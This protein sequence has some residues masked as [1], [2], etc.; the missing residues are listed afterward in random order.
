MILCLDIGNSQIYGGVFDNEKIKLKFRKISTQGSS[1]DEYGLFLKSV[2][3]E[4]GLDPNQIKQIAICS[5]VPD[6]IYSICNC[7]KKYFNLNSYFLQLGV[8]CVLI[9]IYR[10]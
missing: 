3:R 2:L 6:L 8:K 9:I 10:K 4:N 7:C 1:S 5:V